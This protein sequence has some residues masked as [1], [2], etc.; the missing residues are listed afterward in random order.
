MNTQLLKQHINAYKK[1]YKT[2]RT[3]ADL[4]HQQHSQLAGDTRT[5][6]RDRLLNMSEDDLYQYIA[7]LWA[8]V[9]WGNKHYQVDN[10][11]E[12]NGMPLLRQQFASLIWGDTSID[13]RWDEFRKNVKLVGPAIMSELLCKAH[14][15][16]YL[17]W[18]KKTYNAFRLLEIPNLPRYDARLN[19]KTYHYLSGKG[20]EM[21]QI[22]NNEQCPGIHDMLT[23]NAFIWHELRIDPDTSIAQEKPEELLP[24][25][26]KDA[27]FIHNDIRDKL[28]DIGRWLGFYAEVEKKVA[29][30]AIVD[31][32][33]E[34]TIGNMGRVIY[35]FEVQTSGSIDSL[36]LNLMKAR[37][38]KAV[39]GI[40]AV[41][42]SKQIEKIKREV[43]ELKELK[44]ELKF[45]D[46]TEVLKVHESLQ[47]TN[48]CIN[49]LK[50]VPIS[51]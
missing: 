50:L 20:Q 24:K 41:T 23:L 28:A 48:E 33:W 39:Q 5:F 34:V 8:M 10:I 22:L 35:L 46:Y 32:I 3:K 42:D 38:N 44:G 47:F 4:D 40:V 49:N 12:A 6:T 15:D 30:G 17:I 37:N 51:F 14:P 19:G 36:I 7:P 21:L 26:P 9:M 11:I 45:W 27:E 29:A 1:W 25:S 18:N 13:K 31:T 43:G 2:N 16:K